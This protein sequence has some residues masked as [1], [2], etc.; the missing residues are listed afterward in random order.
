MNLLI[1]DMDGVLLEPLGYHHAL[2][3]TVRLAGEACG[4][5]DVRLNAAQIAR[6]EALGIS[7]EWHSS[8]LCMAWM[9]LQKEFAPDSQSPDWERLAAVFQ[10]QPQADSPIRRGAAALVQV[11]QE[12]GVSAEHATTLM[13]EC[14]SLQTSPTFNWFQEL[15]LGS[16]AFERIYGK[17]GQLNTDSYLEKYDRKLLEPAWAGRVADWARQPGCGAG[18]MTSRPSDGPQGYAQEPD[19]GLGAELVGLGELPLIGNG[20]MRW[21]AEKLGVT[22]AEVKKPAAMHALAALLAAGGW[23]LERSLDYL[24]GG[25]PHMRREDLAWLDGSTVIV[26]E[27]T[28][29]G[30]LAMR[31]AGALLEEID[32]RVRVRNVGVATDAA[33]VAALEGM[34]A[35]VFVDV[36]CALDCILATDGH[37]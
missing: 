13:R 11:G 2:Q 28:I 32:V 37:R 26:V 34:G 15:V 3:E 14:E 8:A 20:E 23:P 16:A 30:L 17:A 5:S 29:S 18:I 4:F 24:A 9:A 19:G 22:V 31:A 27:D 25:F 21:L 36:N 12:Q 6:F 1:F 35:Q 7:S 33:K 10:R